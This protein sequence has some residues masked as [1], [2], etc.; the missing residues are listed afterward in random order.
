MP[1][2]SSATFWSLIDRWRVSDDQA[3]ELISYEGKLTTGRPR[4]RLSA[5]QART[6]SPCSRLTAL[7]PPPASTRHGCTSRPTGCPDRRWI[8]GICGSGREARASG[9]ASE[10]AV[11]TLGR[12]ARRCADAR[13]ASPTSASL[14]PA[15]AAR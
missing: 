11:M 1:H 12:R 5:E 9:K 2:P 7:S 15:G 3:L 4:F 6:V 8:S 13:A 14:L 10:E